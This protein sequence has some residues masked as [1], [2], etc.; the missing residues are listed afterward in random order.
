MWEYKLNEDGA[1]HGPFTSRQMLEW[2]SCGYFVGASAVDIRQV[3]S[4]KAGDVNEKTDVD[5][6]MAD[7][8]EDEEVSEEKTRSNE[9]M[10]SDAVD[11]NLYL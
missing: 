4:G 1:I 3:G 9:W 6:L 11:F 5:D 2:T 7:L 10:R 8:M